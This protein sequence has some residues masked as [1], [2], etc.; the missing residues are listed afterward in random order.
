M[1]VSV[2]VAFG[3][4]LHGNYSKE[5]YFTGIMDILRWGYDV[6]LLN[7][8]LDNAALKIVNYS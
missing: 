3:G 1:V 5:D 8:D 7:N 6:L 2:E 4:S